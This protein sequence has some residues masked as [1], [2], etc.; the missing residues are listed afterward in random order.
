MIYDDW[1]WMFSFVGTHCICKQRPAN[2][3]FLL[4]YMISLIIHEDLTKKIKTARDFGYLIWITIVFKGLFSP[5]SPQFSFR[6]KKRR[7]TLKTLFEQISKRPWSER[8]HPPYIDLFQRYNFSALSNKT[9]IWSE[10]I[11][12][13]S[14]SNSSCALVRFQIASMI[15]DQNCT[16]RRSIATLLD[17][18]WN[19]TMQ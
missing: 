9:P 1:Y 17:P 16:T 8:T 19:R 15:W 5:F 7:Q 14:K 12:V 6:S 4:L 3:I 10:I 13:I 2:T 18:S 11:R